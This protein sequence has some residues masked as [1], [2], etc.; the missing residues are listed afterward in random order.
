MNRTEK[1]EPA[2]AGRRRPHGGARRDPSLGCADSASE[3]VG[4]A[5]SP[6]ETLS[7][8]AYRTAD[9]ALVDYRLGNGSGLDLCAEIKRSYPDVH[10]I[11]FTAFGNPQL[12]TEA[13]RAGASGYVLKDLNTESLPEILWTVEESGSYFDSRLAGETAAQHPA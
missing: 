9:V 11:I 3:L 12:L 4:E 5:A 1:Q 8:L 2:A 7:L 13:I 6:T 10:V